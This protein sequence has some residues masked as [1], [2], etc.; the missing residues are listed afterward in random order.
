ME[1]MECQ[2]PVLQVPRPLQ[3]MVCHRLPLHKVLD[4]QWLMVKCHKPSSLRDTVRCHRPSS[5]WV[6]V[7]CHRLSSHRDTVCH[8]SNNHKISEDMA[9]TEEHHSSERN[10]FDHPLHLETL[11]LGPSA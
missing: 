5:Q 8:S 4:S 11:A 10:N 9:D 2:Q 7:R 6:T 3:D 1:V